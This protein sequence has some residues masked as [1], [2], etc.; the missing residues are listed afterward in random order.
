MTRNPSLSIHYHWTQGNIPNPYGL[1]IIQATGKASSCSKRTTV[2]CCSTFYASVRVLLGDF[3]L[4]LMFLLFFINIIKYWLRRQ[5]EK[6]LDGDVIWKISKELL[7]VT[8]LFV[9]GAAVTSSWYA[10]KLP[11]RL[12]E[13]GMTK[14]WVMLLSPS[15]GMRCQNMEPLI[16]RE[17]K[18]FLETEKCVWSRDVNRERKEPHRWKCRHFYVKALWSNF[19]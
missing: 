1:V 8:G 15:V 2:I 16:I 13:E 9:V 10:L 6:H 4:M 19:L 7:S 17:S 5:H 18:Y 11:L 14:A 3:N 12:S